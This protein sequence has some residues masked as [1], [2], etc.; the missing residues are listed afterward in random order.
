MASLTD[1][2]ARQQRAAE[3]IRNGVK[4]KQAYLEAGYAPS[5]ARKLYRLRRLPMIT[6]ALMKKD[7]DK[8]VFKAYTLDVAM[9][10]AQ[11]AA[12]FAI[13]QGNANAYVKACELRCKL[14][15]LLVE[16]VEVVAID[17]RGAIN[18]ATTR[19]GTLRMIGD[20]SNGVSN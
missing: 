2:E 5:S 19:V 12:D 11:H 16:R 18:R 1:N 4:E 7:P 8:L 20:N 13:R 3:L 9:E 15:G 14:S 6:K 17:L 10:Q